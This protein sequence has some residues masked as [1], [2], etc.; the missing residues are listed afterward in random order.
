MLSRPTDVWVKPKAS[1]KIYG[2]GRNRDIEENF[3]ASESHEA[4]VPIS[5][6]VAVA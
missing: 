2:E 3:N 6:Q 4:Q 5:V 1:G